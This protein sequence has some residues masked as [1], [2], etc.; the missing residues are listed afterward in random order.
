MI[1]PMAVDVKLVLQ[2]YVANQVSALLLALNI[3]LEAWGWKALSFFLL[4]QLPL[5]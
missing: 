1:R 3:I 2:A 4:S 5:L